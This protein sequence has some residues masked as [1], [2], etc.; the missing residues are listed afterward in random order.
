MEL[1]IDLHDYKEDGRVGR[2]FTERGIIRKGELYLLIFDKSG[3]YVFPGGGKDEGEE[4][5]E[6]LIREM[7]EET[8]YVVVKDTIKHYITVFERR[9]GRYD[10]IL[11][12]DSYFYFCQVYDKEGAKSLSAYEAEHEYENRWVTLEEAYKVNKEVLDRE[13]CSCIVRDTKVMEILLNENYLTHEVFPYI[14]NEMKELVEGHF[15]ERDV[16]GCSGSQ[17]LLFD[18][19]LVLKIEQKRE[20]SDGEAKMLGWLLGK[21]PVP[22]IV[23]FHSD[24]EKNYLLMTRLKGDMACDKKYLTD[25]E[26]LV[27]LLAKGLKMLWKVDISQCPRKID[28]EYKLKRALEFV[29][30]GAVDLDDVEEDTFGPDGFQNPMELY[31]YLNDNRPIEEPVLIHGDY[32]LPNVF[33]LHNEVSGFLDLGYC[34]IGDKWQDIALAVRS[35]EH[36]L[37][38]AGLKEE[39]PK[40]YDSFFKELGFPPDEEKIRYYKLLDELF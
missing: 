3:Y 7:K 12:M 5:Q 17:I 36:N 33:T 6:T 8:G 34:G 25:G 28:L 23:R 20:E 31:Q 14:P 40:L 19:D 29:T 16:T 9:R 22:K 18:H 32:C 30:T 10:D 27:K 15:Y 35:L 26:T 1:R 24:G 38:E 13:Y 37:C 2:R 39:Y 4:P 11:E 21:V